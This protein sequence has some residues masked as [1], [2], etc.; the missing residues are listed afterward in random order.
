MQNVPENKAIVCLLLNNVNRQ[1]E[2]LKYTLKDIV[3]QR[4]NKEQSTEHSKLSS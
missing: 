1:K 4:I 2:T 3:T